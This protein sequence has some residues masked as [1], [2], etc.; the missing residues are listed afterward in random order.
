MVAI[1]SASY[2]EPLAV[3][4]GAMIALVSLTV[5]TVLVGNKL[6]EKIPM[7]TIN[8]VVPV[9]FIVLGILQIIFHG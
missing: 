3:I 5:L 9:I 8:K 4:I 7:K 2:A 1:L 6:T